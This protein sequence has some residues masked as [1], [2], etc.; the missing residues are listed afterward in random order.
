MIPPALFKVNFNILKM[1][2]QTVEKGGGMSDQVKALPE[3]QKMPEKVIDP[4]TP[5]QVGEE[6]Q[7]KQ[8][9]KCILQISDLKQQSAVATQRNTLSKI[10]IENAM[11]KAELA[12]SYKSAG[13]KEQSSSTAEV[14]TPKLCIPVRIGNGYKW[15]HGRHR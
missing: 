3:G 12:R 4:S 6:P 2:A 7:R 8:T 15:H 13:S 9:L 11:L 5:V 14:C 10:L 1:S